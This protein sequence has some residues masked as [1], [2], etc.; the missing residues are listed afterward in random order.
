MV[1]KVIAALM[2]SVLALSGC[3]RDF[4]STEN[5]AEP[6]PRSN[7]VENALL[8][9]IQENL[10]GVLMDELSQG[11]ADIIEASNDD[12]DLRRK[13]AERLGEVVIQSRS[14]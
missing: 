7:T 10:G 8:S 11:Q 1:V 14:V 13:L 4:A 6:P 9:A 5:A 12:S 2:A 3:N